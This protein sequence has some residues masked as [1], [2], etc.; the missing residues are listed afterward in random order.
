M[1]N[2]GNDQSEWLPCRITKVVVMRAALLMVTDTVAI[3]TDIYAYI[4]TDIRYHGEI[5]IRV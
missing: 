5:K 3:E 4:A 2:K 1:I